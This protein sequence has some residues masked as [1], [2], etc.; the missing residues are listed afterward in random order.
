MLRICDD[1]LDLTFPA[2]SSVT[3]LQ[4]SQIAKKTAN[5]KPAIFSIGDSTTKNAG[6]YSKYIKKIRKLKRA[7]LISGL[8]KD[9]TQAGE[10][11]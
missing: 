3:S 10:I 7:T 4:I 11:V 5:E 9:Y 1:V 6:H 8:T 2:D